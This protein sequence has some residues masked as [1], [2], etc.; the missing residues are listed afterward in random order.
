MF[1]NNDLQ[2]YIFSFPFSGVFRIMQLLVF[3]LLL[4]SSMNTSTI[5]C[6]AEITVVEHR[7]HRV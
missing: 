1:S 6:N 5:G 3:L 4:L 2:K 7:E